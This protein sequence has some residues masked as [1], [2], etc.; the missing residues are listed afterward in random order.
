MCLKCFRIVR[1]GRLEYGRKGF[2]GWMV[3]SI[4]MMNEFFIKVD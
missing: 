2:F 3:L 4:L 1:D